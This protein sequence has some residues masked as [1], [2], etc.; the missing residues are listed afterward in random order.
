[1]HFNHY[2]SVAA[3]YAAALAN[4]PAAQAGFQAVID[5]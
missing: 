3:A 4:A 1:V 2:G 5:E